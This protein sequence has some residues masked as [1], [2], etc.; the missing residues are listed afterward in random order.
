MRLVLL[1]AGLGLVGR[2]TLSRW[3]DRPL[4][5]FEGVNAPAAA[6]GDGAGY[7]SGSCRDLTGRI[8]WRQE[9]RVGHLS[10]PDGLALDPATGDLYVSEEDPSRIQRIRED[11]RREV[12]FDARTPVYRTESGH[13][14]RVSGLRSPE[15]LAMDR[16]GRLYVVEDI[17]GGRVIVFSVAAC[18]PGRRPVGHV[19]DLPLPDHP[20]AWECI[21][22]GPAGELLLAGSSAEAAGRTR[23]GL[24]LF[25]GVVLY[26]DPSGAWWMPIRETFASYSAAAF[27]TDG[28]YAYVASEFPGAVGCLDLQTH[29]VRRRNLDHAFDSPE[30]LYTLP[31]N[32]VLIA[33]ETGSIYRF[34]PVTDALELIFHGAASF[35]S[36]A[37]D[38]AHRRM[39]ITDDRAGC[40][41]ALSADLDFAPVFETPPRPDFDNSVG[42]GD[43]PLTCP[44]YLRDILCNAGYDPDHGLPFPELAR[45]LSMMAVDAVV[46]PKE[47]AASLPD[48]I[49][50]LQFLAVFPNRFDLMNDDLVTPV[51]AFAA[52]TR[53]GKITATRVV[54]RSVLHIDLWTGLISQ[55]GRQGIPLP[56]PVGASAGADG[57]ASIHFM[58][59]GEMPDY[60]V[61]LNPLHPEESYLAV[62]SLE[63]TLDTYRLDLPTGV[64]PSY[65]VL[66]PTREA[67]ET[68]VR[69]A[70]R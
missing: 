53:S 1:T 3:S 2:T 37:W 24:T 14:T 33:D 27:S 34:D 36:V 32:S 66:A 38:P 59:M 54:Q 31:D 12:A 7:A 55:L 11:G 40:L 46:I 22:V 60:H 21:A 28:S 17:P 13:A 52:V 4:P 47:R 63:G 30:G 43:L 48:P 42:Q 58:G 64:P 5:E 41:L 69:L 39:L 26:R 16:L 70:G 25:E 8:D 6:G 20:Y 10:S 15:G 51:S 9:E 57:M 50:R 61:G 65:W 44:N 35:E 49:A 62:M 68:W 56:Y 23:D 19:L 29:E 45:R 67:P 18:P